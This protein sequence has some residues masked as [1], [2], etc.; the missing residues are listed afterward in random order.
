MIFISHFMRF[1]SIERNPMYEPKHIPTLSSSS[2]ILGGIKYLS[3]RNTRMVSPES[4]EL[5]PAHLHSFVE[6]FFNVNADVS[7]LLNGNM[8]NVPRGGALISRRDDIHVC[9]FNSHT[10]HDYFCFWIDL[11][12]G[13]PLGDI[14]SSDN[15][16][17]SILLKDKSSDMEEY[18]EA[19]RTDDISELERAAA[20]IG[21]FRLLTAACSDAI[22][23][24]APLP[25]ALT[26]VL[27]DIRENLTAIRSVGELADRHFIST[28][29]L[30]RYFRRYFMMTPH[31][32][33]E[34]QR[35]SRAVKML[36]LGASVTDACHDSGF[37]D[38][39]HFIMLFKSRFGTT[40]NKYKKM[41]N[42][43]QSK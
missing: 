12:D 5:D 26:A 20:I 31:E 13:S 14:L 35:L 29:T 8:Y 7:F 22:I 16:T 40:P 19:L 42:A 15:F 32:Y 36:T 27:N 25:T 1:Q 17:P 38:L 11:P 24:S 3:E 30:N 6:I 39:S 23:P 4:D 37:P 34:A 10:V 2:Q 21:I 28:A 18:L 33:L 43:R 41:L 9:I